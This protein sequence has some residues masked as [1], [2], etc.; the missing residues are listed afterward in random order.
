MF[1]IIAKQVVMYDLP[2]RSES[3]VV[4]YLWEKKVLRHTENKVH[5]FFV[6]FLKDIS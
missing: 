2:R 6:F 5:V 1:L 3:E 4:H